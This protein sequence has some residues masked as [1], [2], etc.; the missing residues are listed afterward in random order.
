MKS[1]L[2]PILHWVGGKQRLLP[3]LLKYVPTHFNTYYEC[4]AGGLALMWQLH[5]KNV[6]I[7]DYNSDLITLYKILAQHYKKPA[8]VFL[9]YP[10]SA[11]TSKGKSTLKRLLSYYEKCN[12]HDA[13]YKIRNLDQDRIITKMTPL[14]IAARF[15]YLDKNGFNGVMRYSHTGYKNG[16]HENVPYGRHK[17]STLITPEMSADAKYL[18]SINIKFYSG[19]FSSSI[20]NA[21]VGDFIYA[22]PPYLERPKEFASSFTG[23]TNKGFGINDQKRLA[24]IALQMKDNG[25]KMMLSNADVPI[26]KKLYPSKY[27]NIHHISIQTLISSKNSSR[28]KTGEVIITNY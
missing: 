16:K 23:Y 22:D 18:S 26:I 4:F 7:N 2:K 3:Q 5:P 17:H 14:D 6:V 21:K 24:K 25:V 1:K 13:Y 15:V 9:K 12:N 28:K 10:T 27:F 8:S 19:D 20:K 11:Y